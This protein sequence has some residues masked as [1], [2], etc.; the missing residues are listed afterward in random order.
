MPPFEGRRDT[1]SIHGMEEDVNGESKIKGTSIP[2]I[3]RQV[4]SLIVPA[5]GADPFI[6]GP[7]DL[8]TLLFPLPLPVMI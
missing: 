8:G 2:V 5:A 7:A 6:A 3:I 1:D 4:A